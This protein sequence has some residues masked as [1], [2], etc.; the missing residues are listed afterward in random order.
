MFPVT[1]VVVLLPV[2]LLLV[3]VQTVLVVLA[4]G[5]RPR[6]TLVMALLYVRLPLLLVVL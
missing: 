3:A 2:Q 4:V 1:L 6:V 5:A